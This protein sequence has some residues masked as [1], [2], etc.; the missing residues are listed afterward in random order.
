MTVARLFDVCVGV[1]YSG[2]VGPSDRISGL[3][4]FRSEGKAQ[5]IQVLSTCNQRW[6]RRLVAEYL[7]HWLSGPHP[8]I[9]IGIDHAFSFP[10]MSLERYDLGSWDAFLDYF[11]E[12]WR[13][14]ERSVEAAMNQGAPILGESG[15]LRLTDRWTSSAKSVFTLDGPGQVGKS[16]HA[17]IPW[18][19]HLRRQL[20][21][22][23]HFWPF[24]GF[25]VPEGKSVIAEVYPALFKKRYSVDSCLEGHELDAYAVCRWLQERDELGF[26][27]QYFTPLLSPQE[28]EIAL[29]EGWI[30]G[31][32]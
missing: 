10:K 9:I 4:V 19:W 15:L 7:R 12:I 1:D 18:L 2:A 31:I 27:A 16:T 6:S 17:G 20:G 26:L 28:A 32:M 30:L 25:K 14:D 3:K 8:S 29:L 5:P 11:R 23:V 24:D 13:T 21:N 22:L